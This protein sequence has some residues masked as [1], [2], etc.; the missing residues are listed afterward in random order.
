MRWLVQIGDFFIHPVYC[1]RIL[2]EIVCSDTQKVDLSCERVGTNGGAWNFDHCAN[3]EFVSDLDVRIAQ[4]LFAFV[5]HGHGAAQFI[6]AGDHWKHDFHVADG[7]GS[8]NGAQLGLEN[9]MIPEAKPDGPPTKKWVQL[10]ADAYWSTSQ[11]VATQ[12]KCSN[13]QGVRPD[14][15]RDVSINFV[16]LLLAGQSVAVQIQKLRPI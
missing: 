8:E 5:E 9:V 11:F 2:N 16:L 15:F 14:T 12:I 6:Q 1:Q 7:A 3:F 10:V 4:L 13:N